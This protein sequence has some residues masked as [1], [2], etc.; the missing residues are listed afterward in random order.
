MKA[1]DIIM[2]VSMKILVF[3]EGNFSPI[4]AW[5]FGNTAGTT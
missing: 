2:L 1:A 3:I 4:F 5:L